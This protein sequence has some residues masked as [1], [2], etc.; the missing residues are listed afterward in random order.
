MKYLKTFENHKNI[1]N[2]K[3]NGLDKTSVDILLSFMNSKL[4]DDRYIKSIESGGNDCD[5]T[6]MEDDM[7]I[8]GDDMLHE[9]FEIYGKENNGEYTLEIDGYIFTTFK[10][11]ENWCD[12]YKCLKK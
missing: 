12:E 6:W 10:N 11:G 9:L 5:M 7:D 1:K 3:I 2:I 4:T 8:S